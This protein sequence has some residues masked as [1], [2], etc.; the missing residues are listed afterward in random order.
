MLGWLRKTNMK[1][2]NKYVYMNSKTT[3]RHSV[4]L[5]QHSYGCILLTLSSTARSEK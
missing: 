2:I 4:S 1:K 5:A 3:T